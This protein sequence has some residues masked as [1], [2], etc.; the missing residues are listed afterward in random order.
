MTWCQG[1]GAA[2]SIPISAGL[3]QPFLAWLSRHGR[4]QIA[5]IHWQ[6]ISGMC[7][8][9]MRPLFGCPCCSHPSFKL[10]DLHGELY[11]KRCAAARGA[12]YQS[13]LQSAKGRPLLQS[14]RLR[15]FLGEYP[16]YTEIHRAPWMSHKT[17]SR[18]LHRL[19]QLE[20]QGPNKHRQRQKAKP[21]PHTTLR[22][23]TMYKTRIASIA[24]A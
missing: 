24:M 7:Q 12:I 8:G 20:A 10:Y 17:Y 15:R 13:Q 11:C 19:R 9:T 23:V 1:I 2:V 16:N 18:L 3:I 4:Q 5:S 22:P 14:Q 21:L 6:A